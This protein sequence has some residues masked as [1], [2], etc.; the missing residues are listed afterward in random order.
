MIDYGPFQFAAPPYTGAEWFATAVER[1]GLNG[2]GDPTTPFPENSEGFR[3][4]LVRH[5]VDWLR[6]VWND[7]HACKMTGLEKARRRLPFPAFLQEYLTA[8]PG[9]VGRTYR[10]YEADSVIRVE[11]CPAALHEFLRSLGAPWAFLVGRHHFIGPLCVYS[12]GNADLPLALRREVCE[13][14]RWVLE[15]YDYW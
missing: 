9:I 12:F 7:G 10:C 15:Q 4:G 3:I 11:D 14:E 5:P 1:L 13:A 8:A 6:A 2:E